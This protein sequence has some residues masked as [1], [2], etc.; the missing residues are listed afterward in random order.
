MASCPT[1]EKVSATKE[2]TPIG[3]ANITIDTIF[4]HIS[5]ALSNT[6]LTGSAFSPIILIATPVSIAKN[7]ICNMSPLA[8]DAIGFVGIIP[9]SISTI[10]LLSP[11]DTSPVTTELISNPIPGFKTLPK[12]KAITIAKAVVDK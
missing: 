6:F 3:A 12:N 8:K 10:D 7:I 2:N 1:V 5:L 4:I 9:T 11:M